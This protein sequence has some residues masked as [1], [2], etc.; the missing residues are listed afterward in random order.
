MLNDF[1]EF[2]QDKYQEDFQKRIVAMKI[3]N[4]EL[5]SD[6][7]YGKSITRFRADFSQVFVRPI[8]KLTDGV[9]DPIA[10]SA[11]TLTVDRRYGTKFAIDEVEEITQAGPLQPAIKFGRETARELAI[12]VD[13]FV[14]SETQNA[15][16]DFDTGNLTTRNSSGVPI[17]LTTTNVEQV[18][19]RTKARL[20]RN[21]IDT[22][23]LAWVVDADMASI[24]EEKFIGK[25]FDMAGSV[26]KNGLSGSVLGA[27]VYVSE[28][29]TGEALF[30]L[31][32][33]PTAGDTILVND[34]EV[35]F[36][37]ALTGAGQVLIGATAADTYS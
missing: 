11:E 13:A 23:N 6:L 19:T 7:T 18:M 24:F 14:L 4:T 2:F 30:T 3:A 17:T 35:E 28:N 26:W 10:D 5:R 34:I 33:N 15:F 25:E 31:D 22:E 20:R 37:A 21:N 29:L 12:V 8:T 9:I 27:E 16:A 36:V 32:T 1:A